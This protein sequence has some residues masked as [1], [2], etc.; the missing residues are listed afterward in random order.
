MVREIIIALQNYKGPYSLTGKY[1]Y[2]SWLA[3][4]QENYNSVDL[5]R[6][7][8]FSE[9]FLPF[10]SFEDE[11]PKI[12]H[13][14]HLLGTSWHHSLH[15]SNFLLDGKLV[16]NVGLW[17]D[18]MWHQLHDA[19]RLLLVHRP[20]S[21]CDIFRSFVLQIDQQ[22]VQCSS[23]TS[24]DSCCSSF[25]LLSRIDRNFCWSDVEKRLNL[26]CKAWPSPWS[27][28]CFAN[29]R[30]LHPYRTFG[31][32]LD[33]QNVPKLFQKRIPEKLRIFRIIFHHDDDFHRILV[34]E[35]CF[36]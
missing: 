19:V 27:Q 23:G 33:L 7:R 3:R 21:D 9:L 28:K 32:L 1:S 31:F 10:H 22:L 20:Y 2:P 6:D 14:S 4:A 16:P 35:N 30:T 12:Q 24:F 34:D 13:N 5:L 11:N 8:N 18:R 29:H 36:W 26:H 17:W 25:G 15:H